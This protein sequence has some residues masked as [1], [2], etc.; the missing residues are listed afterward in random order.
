[1]KETIHMHRVMR[2][3]T[4]KE[5]STR[6]RLQNIVYLFIYSVFNSRVSNSDSMVSKMKVTVKNKL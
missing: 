2:L 6:I 3:G 1:M 4:R 5:L